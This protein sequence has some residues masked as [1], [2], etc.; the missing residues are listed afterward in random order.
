[1]PALVD[2]LRTA[3]TTRRTLL[4]ALEQTSQRRP[5]PSW[6]AVERQMRATTADWRA[7]L[8]RDVSTVRQAFRELLTTPIQCTPGVEN[9]YRAIRFS[10]RLGLAAMFGGVVTNVAFPRGFAKGWKHDSRAS[11]PELDAIGFFLPEIASASP[12][13]IGPARL[14]WHSPISIEFTSQIGS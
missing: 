10:G 5:R 11:R 7:R 13:V 1:V 4:A 14:S 8:R 3:E 2:R 6:D 9:G 12:T